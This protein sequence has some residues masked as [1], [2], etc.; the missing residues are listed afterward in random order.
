MDNK[1]EY[2]II[3]LGK[4][5][6]SSLDY[7]YNN[8]TT[9]IG[10]I[11]ENIKD[12]KTC[13]YSK[14]KYIS[15]II[16]EKYL[17][18]ATYIVLSPGIDP[19][20]L[21]SYKKKIIN[22]ISIFMD[23][24]N[25]PVIV[26]TGT[27][28]KST[29]V[30]LLTHVLN[31]SGVSAISGGNIG[32]PCLELLKY[33]KDYYILELSS[34][35]LDACDN[36]K[37]NISILLNITPNHMDRYSSFAEYADSKK[38]IF[39]SSK[40]C[41]FN[42]EDQLTT[43]QNIENPQYGFSTKLDDNLNI[44]KTHNGYALFYQGNSILDESDMNF[45][46]KHN[47][48]NSLVVFYISKHINVPT[49]NIV[50]SMKSFSSLEH[51]CEIVTNKNGVIWI[52][53]SKSTNVNST[54]VALESISQKKVHLI[55]G[56]ISKS[57]KFSRLLYYRNNIVFI[58]IYGQSS[59]EIYNDMFEFKHKYISNSLD[60][61]IIRINK[62]ISDNQ[63]VLFSPGCSSLDMFIDFNHRG[64]VFKKLVKR[65]YEIK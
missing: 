11:D 32:T 57:D 26:V 13:Q 47:M 55:L 4:T 25:A 60:D 50:K 28:G 29:V 1:V 14:I 64:K 5:G 22:D 24:C 15:D 17:Q 21:I 19:R 34:Y 16:D 6:T 2:L 3:G 37:S 56:G 62:N 45:F 65:L 23:V 51:R 10:I 59:E 42:L 12:F 52:N 49:N 40:L 35:Q 53:D 43:P 36:L 38:K 33:K 44:K 20:R 48:L 7:L 61:I 9:S 18:D 31:S 41:I 46:G 27:N 8:V 30:S 58:Y 54:M 39:K 63:V